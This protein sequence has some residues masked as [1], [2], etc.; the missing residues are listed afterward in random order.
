MA[1]SITTEGRQHERLVA[2]GEAIIRTA[3][4]QATGELVDVS[5]SGLLILGRIPVSIGESVEVSFTPRDYPEEVKVRGRVARVRPDRVGIAFS[6]TRWWQSAW[7]KLV[8]FRTVSQ[9]KIEGPL[10]AADLLA[11]IAA[12]QKEA[13]TGDI[14]VKTAAL[15]KM[16]S[17]GVTFGR[18]AQPG[19][20][21]RDPNLP[22][23]ARPIV[24]VGMGGAA[25]EVANFD[26]A[27]IMR[28]IDSLAHPDYRLFGYEQIGAMLGVYEKTVPRMMLGLKPL[29]RPPDVKQFI[30]SFDDPKVRR[31]ISHGYG[32]LLY[33]NSKHVGAA[34]H[35]VKQREFLDPRAAVQGMGFG[36]AMVNHRELG[37]VLETG[38]VLVVFDPTFVRAFQAGLVYAL[39]FWEWVSP[40]FLQTLGFANPR[41]TEL[42]A[43]ARTEIESARQ[44]GYLEPFVVE[45]MSA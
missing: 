19:D 23:E 6:E 21:L 41:A 33:F 22:V 2:D 45:R 20:T 14:A 24:H 44:R 4:G 17:L 3:T 5:Q 38:D 10:T 39:M 9:K 11:R 16:E 40:G 36:Y 13:E 8:A 26:R 30:L 7:R 35:N 28:R 34:Y 42:V 29:D 12:I 27:E 43:T 25:V 37:T 32:R 18:V 1:H 31:L 15:W